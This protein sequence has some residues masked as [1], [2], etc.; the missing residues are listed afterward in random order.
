MS[1][2]ALFLDLSLSTL[3]YL[4]LVYPGATVAKADR[5]NQSMGSC[6]GV[7]HSERTTAITLDIVFSFVFDVWQKYCCQTESRCV[8]AGKLKLFWPVHEKRKIQALTAQASLPASPPRKWKELKSCLSR[9]SSSTH[10]WWRWET[11]TEHVGRDWRTDGAH[12]SR[13]NWVWYNPN[14]TNAVISKATYMS[15]SRMFQKVESGW[16]PNFKVVLEC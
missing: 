4:Y 9:V 12:G 16:G 13:A 11:C 6:F 7:G 3:A 5:A 1:I 15:H 14:L 10:R 8:W 2:V